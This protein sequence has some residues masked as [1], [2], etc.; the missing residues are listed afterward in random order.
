MGGFFGAVSKKDCVL[1]IFFGVDYHS[2]L[3]ARRGGMVVY[4]EKEGFTRQI[5]NIESSPFR[6]K[7]EGNLKDFKGNSGMGCISDT[8]P[9]PLLVRSHL[10]LFAITTVGIINNADQLVEEHFTGKG[11]QF[12]AMSSGAVN[13][14]EL[15]AALINLKD[16]LVSGIR[17]A[18]ELIEG[19]LTLLILTDKG[20]IIAGRDR[21]G[22]LPVLIGQKEDG[23]CVA[24]ES[25]S[26]Q[27]L[28]YVDAY[29]LGP[30][31]I[32]KI[33]AE[34]YETLSPAGEKMRICSF[35]WSYFGYPTACYE[36]INVE[37]M[38]CKNGANMAERELAEGTLPDVDFVAGMPD[39]GIPHA[40]G[41]AN[42]SNKGYARPFIKY[43]PTWPR[44]FVSANQDVRKQVAKMKQIPVNALIDG[45]KLLFIDDSI[46][47]GTQLQETV[48]FLYESGAKEVHMRSACP[49]IMYACKYLNFSRSNSDMDLLCRRTI[50]E[51][52]G[53][54]G[55]EHVD[56]YADPTTE[57][58]K[59]MRRAICRKFGFDSLGYQTLEGLLESIG[60]DTDKV[61]TYCWTGKE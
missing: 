59:N 47:R 12:M 45:K 32:V 20:E 3:S 27:K 43:T 30:G 38:R 21:L 60:L 2:H 22:R 11:Q 19:S 5:H 50:Q 52:E 41:Y 55:Q 49:P 29:E 51:L 4:D 61:C 28:D 53:N 14:T 1:D 16:D 39:S 40:I 33:T 31:E 6:T 34:G 35:L 44:S 57:R 42:R 25:F 8:D 54:I 23:C 46:V 18:Q 58:G 56:E 48:E 36:G 17:Y 24:F 26:Y 7:F 13:A 10:G 37:V 15:A 9:Q